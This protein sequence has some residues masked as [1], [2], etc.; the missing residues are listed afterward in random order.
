[1]LAIIVVNF[2]TLDFNLL[3][4]LDA[5]L[6]ERSTTR[7]GES[8]GLSQPAV[9]A[10]LRRLRESLGDPLFVRQG[11]AMVPTAFA[12]A[13]EEPLRRALDLLKDAL[14]GGGHF[15]PAGSERSFRIFG[16]DFYS[17]MLMP[18]LAERISRL[19]PRMRLQLVYQ[20]E[21]AFARQLSEG[22]VDM[23]LLPPRETP[24]WV[25]RELAFHS[26]FV[27]IAGKHNAAIARAGI[28]A[29]KEIPIDLFCDMPHVLF[30]PEGNLAGMEDRALARIGRQRRV[31]LT[32][33][34]FYG[35]G[36][37]VA[38]SHY[39]AILPARFALS[40]SERLGLDVYAIPHEM[41]LAPQYLYWH[42]R[43]SADPAHRWMRETILALLEPLDELRHP[44][45]LG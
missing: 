38:Q 23:A 21:T 13:L 29:G 8:I 27:A 17:E 33:P 10:A 41:P 14:A 35:V 3:R 39:L 44:V 16:S 4:V 12:L 42:R 28:P 2:R 9:S 40:L 34:E 32:V 1:M 5:L 30:S 18:G 7:A 22:A 43:H 36:R 11:N 45:T 26:S 37:V 24:D 31:A 19:A 15:D 25:E 20:D 6:R